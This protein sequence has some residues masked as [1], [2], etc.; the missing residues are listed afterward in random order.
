MYVPIDTFQRS[1]ADF[2][3]YSIMKCHRNERRLLEFKPCS[4]LCRQPLL[5]EY[6]R[7]TVAFRTYKNIC[8]DVEVV[9]MYIRVCTYAYRPMYVLM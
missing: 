6:L 7:Y 1:M 9:P 5:G 4:L 3:P 2:E 8:R